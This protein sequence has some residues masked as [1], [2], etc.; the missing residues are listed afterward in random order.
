MSCKT[1][2]YTLEQAVEK[3][4]LETSLILKWSEENLIRAELPDTRSMRVNG[5][6]LE[7]KIRYVMNCNYR[8]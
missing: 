1:S 8:T 3:Y 2:W 7:Q 6:D 4:C 5:E